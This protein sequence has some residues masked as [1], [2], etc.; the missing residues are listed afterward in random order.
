MSSPKACPGLTGGLTTSRTGAKLHGFSDYEKTGL[1]IYIAK[2]MGMACRED[3]LRRFFLSL[4]NMDW[5]R[6][7][8][9][10]MGNF[11]QLLILK[12]ENLKTSS[13]LDLI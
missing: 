2:E 12:V 13:H 11:G 1:I 5:S 4:D 3:L 7:R 10:S 6:S 9:Y 8:D